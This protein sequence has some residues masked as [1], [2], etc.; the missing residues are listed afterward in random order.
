MKI[1]SI[2][3]CDYK[4]PLKEAIRLPGKIVKEKIGILI[5]IELENGING[6]GDVSPLPGVNEES[7][8]QIKKEARELVS[9]L[10]YFDSLDLEKFSLLKNCFALLPL[11][12]K[13]SPSLIFGLEQ[14]LLNIKLQ[15]DQKWNLLK[16]SKNI[17]CA[18][19]L[20]LN[21]FDNEY[22]LF[23]YVR[24]YYCRDHLVFKIKIGRDIFREE[25]KIIQKIQNK[26]PDIT[27]RLDGNQMLQPEDLIKNI[28]LM[29]NLTIEF[30]EEPFLKQ[31]R[32]NPV[33]IPNKFACDEKLWQEDTPENWN[34]Y[35]DFLVLKPTRIGGCSK[36]L[37]W[38]ERAKQKNKKI[39]V[40]SCYESGAGIHGLMQIILLANIET[41]SGL[42]PYFSLEADLLTAPLSFSFRS[43][44]PYLSLGD[45]KEEYR[46]FHDF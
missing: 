30:I 28:D 32:M 41:A 45:L 39:V 43:K 37:R 3:Y 23:E 8:F 29:K 12:L 38:V 35:E 34:S 5:K 42:S 36:T 13:L 15:L 9:H 22:K 16:S 11:P 2:K 14:A 26:F 17:D 10:F 4:L 20:R 25:L 21:H 31:N 24:Y 6:I 18:I 19:L 44:I 40:S 27:I 33:D 7:I 46:S 1:K